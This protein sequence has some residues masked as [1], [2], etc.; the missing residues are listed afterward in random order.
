MKIFMKTSSSKWFEL[1]AAMFLI[2]QIGWAAESPVGPGASPPTGQ[3]PRPQ[4]RHALTTTDSLYVCS[5]DGA[6]FVSAGKDGRLNY[7]RTSD[8]VVLRSFL[9]CSPMALAFSAD[10]TLLASAGRSCGRASVRVWRVAD[11]KML[12]DLPNDR[13][14]AQGLA[15]S[16]GGQFLACRNGDSEINLWHLANQEL[17]W[18][19]SLPPAELSSR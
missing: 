13:G 8:G 19:I 5:P 4:V 12:H 10:G 3:E 6:Y 16:P 15:F 9:H 1:F 18:F 7:S 2:I 14:G 11:G 17:K